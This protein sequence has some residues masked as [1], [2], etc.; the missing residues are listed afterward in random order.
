MCHHLDL[1]RRMQRV[2][3]FQIMTRKLSEESLAQM[4]KPAR[5]ANS[6][7]G[8]CSS[9][10][11]SRRVSPPISHSISPNMHPHHGGLGANTGSGHSGD[12]LRHSPYGK[13]WI[14]RR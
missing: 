8:T 6:F 14:K 1:N 9:P 10:M 7:S 13:L 5:K 11:M 4:P 2:S 12:E 3:S